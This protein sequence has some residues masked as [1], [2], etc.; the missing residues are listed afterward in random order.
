MFYILIIPLVSQI[1]QMKNTIQT[2]SK[3]MDP[4]LHPAR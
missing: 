4:V 3:G 2:Q 1:D